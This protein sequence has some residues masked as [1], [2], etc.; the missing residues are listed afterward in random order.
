MVEME[1]TQDA[2]AIKSTWVSNRP[3]PANAALLTLGT[4][5]RE[6]AS[7]PSESLM[8]SEW[9]WTARK[10]DAIR[11]SL[12]SLRGKATMIQRLADVGCRD[13]RDAEYYRTVGKAVEVH[14][15]EIAPPPLEQAR[16]RGVIG[17]VWVSG[18]G[19]CPVADAYFDVVVA[20][21]VIEH[22]FDTDAFLSE[23]NRVLR[24][25][26]KL[27]VTTPN[28]AWWWSR[29]R[30]L[31]GKPPAGIGGAS[32]IHAADKAVDRKHLRV[33][34]MG[35]WLHLFTVHGF[36]VERVMGFNYPRLLRYPFWRLDDLL[37]RRVSWAHSL[38]FVL[39]KPEE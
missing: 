2:R 14:G 7:A 4:N 9:A 29:L 32:S 10:R 35:E 17:H 16:R 36:R 26:G 27:I 20:G 33:M 1:M 11:R 24:P 15:F 13:G 5:A 6:Y 3:L 23:L 34:P 21:D 12:L 18:E 37:T 31:G 38:L 22:L 39:D 25:G 30:L 19:P 8:A 28:L